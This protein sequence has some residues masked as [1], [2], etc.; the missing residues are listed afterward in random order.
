MC[1]W[2]CVCVWVYVGGYMCVGIM[3]VG[4]GLLSMPMPRFAGMYRAGLGGGGGGGPTGP[5]PA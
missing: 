1:V 5:A 4:I 2:V 3:W